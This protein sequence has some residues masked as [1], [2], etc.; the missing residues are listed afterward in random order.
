MIALFDRMFD[1]LQARTDL[2]VYREAPQQSLTDYAE[3]RL[4]LAG[5]INGV[6]RSD[7][8]GGYVLSVA[9]PVQRYREVIG[10]VMLSKGGT[11]I[12]QSVRAV[13]F[14]VLEVFAGALVI[15][16]L[17]STVSGGNYRAPG[18]STGGGRGPGPAWPGRHGDGNSGYGPPGR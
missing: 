9:M 14:V 7:G 4:A 15:T 5:E 6:A 10:V 3:T 1:S 13:R 2:D 8:E 16:V 17:L 18:P 11:E 12:Q